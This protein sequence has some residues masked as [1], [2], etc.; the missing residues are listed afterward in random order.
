LFSNTIDGSMDPPMIMSFR[1]A[2]AKR[3][4]SNDDALRVYLSFD[5]GVNWSLRKHHAHRRA[6]HRAQH[7]LA[8]HPERPG[9]MGLL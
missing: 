3:Y 2:F 9:P 6:R 4:S 1:Y 8:L 5:C 7:H